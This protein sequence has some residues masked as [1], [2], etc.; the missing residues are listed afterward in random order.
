MISPDRLDGLVESII[1][2]AIELRRL[3]HRHPEPANEEH[4][5]TALIVAALDEHGIAYSDRHPATGL[6]VDIG[7]DPRIGFRADLDALPIVEPEENA[8][9]SQNPGWMHACGHD[10]HAAIA[11][12]IVV[13]L[14]R[15]DLPAGVRV[16]FQPAEETFPGGASQYVDEG[17]VD[18][19]KGILAFHIDPSLDTGKVGSRV[20]PV[21]ASA[22]RFT[23]VLEGPGGHTARPHQTVDLIA[24]AARLV[25]E[26]PGVLRRTVDARSTLTV[27]F[28]S[29]QGGRSANVIPTRVELQGTARTLDRA[30]W[31]TLPGLM[32]RA[33]GGLMAWS[34]AGYHLDYL[35]AIPPVVNDHVVIQTATAGIAHALGAEALV[36]TE[37]SM[38]GEDFANYL[39]VTPGALLRL[40]SSGKG[41]DLHSPGFVLDEGSI[42]V[43]IRA[44][45]AAV[46]G[47]AEG[48]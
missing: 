14:S 33:I 2:E 11:F 19:L 16:L 26:L 31:E 10:A 23:V 37:P 13:A 8:P 18:G 9:R 17:L 36:P 28:G 6:W 12:G 44:G 47:L 32:D 29:I 15:S 39:A 38:G 3:L 48:L 21:T 5:T 7:P 30:L 27:A 40:G 35:Q 24:D 1:P 45:V 42:G 22:D 20:G 43:G 34:G 41:N 4:E 25:H 46:L